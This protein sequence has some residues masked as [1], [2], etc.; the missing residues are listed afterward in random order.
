ML[1][2]LSGIQKIDAKYLQRYRLTKREDKD[3]GKNKFAD[4]FFAN[5]PSEKQSQ[6]SFTYQSKSN[7]KDQDYHE[8]F[9]YCKGRKQD[10][11]HNFPTISVNI[12][13]K[14]EEKN[15]SHIK[16]FHYKKKN[17]YTLISIFK[18]KTKS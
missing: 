5:V 17:H 11:S 12:I 14:K 6:Q 2:L 15:I 16:C 9:W 8:D 1:L 3:I 4:T 13:S 10:Y 7:K 18:I